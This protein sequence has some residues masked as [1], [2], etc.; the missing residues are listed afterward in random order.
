MAARS[1][2]SEEISIFGQKNRQEEWI[3]RVKKNHGF[4]KFDFRKS[5]LAWSWKNVETRNLY[6][7]STSRQCRLAKI[8]LRKTMIFF[9]TSNPFFLLIFWP[10]IDISSQLRDLAAILLYGEMKKTHSF[11]LLSVAGFWWV[12]FQIGSRRLFAETGVW[13]YHRPSQSTF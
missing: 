10:N 13:R 12:F 6:V 8:E 11:P 3:W 4:S 9:Y 2:S 1:R 5:P 7:F